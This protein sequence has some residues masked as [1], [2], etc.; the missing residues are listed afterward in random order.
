[1]SWDHAT[2]E[3]VR[4]ILSKRRGVVEKRMIGG[5]SFMVDGKLCCGVNRMGLLVRIGPDVCKQVLEQP[6]VRP[7]KLAG[8]TVANL[9]GSIQRLI[10]PMRHWPSGFESA[11]SMHW[12]RPKNRTRQV[13]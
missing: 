9:C 10:T 1:M 11:S 12:L 7:M 8:R 5:L 13:R 2:V 3:R 6:H 4:G